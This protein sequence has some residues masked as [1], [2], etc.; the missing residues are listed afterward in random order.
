MVLST[1]EAPCTAPRRAHRDIEAGLDDRKPQRKE[2]AEGRAGGSSQ[3]AD[4]SV[5][6]LVHAPRVVDLSGPERGRPPQEGG[7]PAIISEGRRP[8][9]ATPRACGK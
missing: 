7:F 1:W 5:V 8:D 4:R 3:P 9:A 6:L 2:R